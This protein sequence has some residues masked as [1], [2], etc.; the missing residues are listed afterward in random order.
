MTDAP[1]PRRRVLLADVAREAGLSPAQTSAALTGYRGVSVSTRRRV[2]EVAEA[3]G[4]QA[5]EH[6]RLLGSRGASRAKRCA[7]VLNEPRSPDDGGDSAPGIAVTPFVSRMLE[8]IMVRASDLD[9]DMRLVHWPD[10]TSGL[11]TLAARDGA[12]AVLVP[13]FLGLSRDHVAALHGSG[14]PFV[15]LNRHFDDDPDGPA[16][17]SDVPA[18]I[19]DVATG[20]ADLVAR[21]VADGHR[22]LA[23]V[24]E[25]SGSSIVA[26]YRSGWQRSTRAQGVEQD[27]RIVQVRHSDPAA[28]QAAL[29]ELFDRPARPTGVVA[30]SE[31]M[32]HEVLLAAAAH[33]LVV[34]D[35]LSVVTFE[36]AIAPYTSPALSSFDLRLSEIGARGVERLAVS[37]GLLDGA[38]TTGTERITPSYVE[39]DSTAPAPTTDRTR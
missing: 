23:L 35:D 37:L 3:L 27:C 6:A 8:G 18:V 5:S 39:R 19:S 1:A 36:S 26:D 10:L 28:R 24:T 12:D 17:I 14:L 11:T 2:R 16:V 32:A 15:L 25:T 34:P 22:R 31:V 33:G 30:V 9:M 21:F 13:S 29:V 4:Y 20:I 38:S 7:I